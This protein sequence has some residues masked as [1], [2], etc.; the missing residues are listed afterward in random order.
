MLSFVIY[1]FVIIVVLL[2]GGLLSSLIAK[3]KPN[4]K[5]YTVAIVLLFVIFFGF[6]IPSFFF[7]KFMSIWEVFQFGVSSLEGIGIHMWL[8]RAIIAA[9]IIPFIMA[10]KASFSLKKSKRMIGRGILVLFVVAYCLTMYFGTREFYFNREDGESDYYIAWTW[11]GPKISKQPGV[12]PK[13]G[14]ELRKMTPEDRRRLAS[15]EETKTEVDSV[16]EEEKFFDPQSGDPLKRYLRNADGSFKFFPYSVYHDPSSG[17]ELPVVTPEI[18]E[19]HFKNQKKLNE[20]RYQEEEIARKE[21]AEE[22]EKELKERRKRERLAFINKYI[23]TSIP[24]PSGGKSYLT[25][26]CDDFSSRS[27]HQDIDSENQINGKL[28][29]LGFRLINNF[30]REAF[31][32][33]GHLHNVFRGNTKILKDLNAFKYSDYLILGQKSAHFFQ[34]EKLSGMISCKLDLNC[35]I[36]RASGEI[37]ESSTISHTGLGIDKQKAEQKATEMIAE[38]LGQIMSKY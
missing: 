27:I 23:D 9:L 38:E 1:F 26:V 24:K 21:K 11:D 22:E 2:L 20:K 36:Y 25:L 34:S 16:P 5:K 33:D 29:S 17:K 15:M 8:A 32:S 12:D 4:L 7:F 28:N 3:K 31:I 35:K 19:E 13:T 30:F 6:I 18:V 37:I 14:K 10:V